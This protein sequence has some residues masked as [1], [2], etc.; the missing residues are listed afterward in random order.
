[1][2]CWKLKG[3]LAALAVLVGLVII[4]GTAFSQGRQDFTLVNK[5]GYDIYE[6]Y[7]SPTKASDWSDDVMDMDIL[8]HG[9][10]VEIVFPGDP[11]ICIWDLAV[12]YDDEEEVEWYNFDLCT[13]SQ[14]TL[15]YEKRSG[16][17]WAEYE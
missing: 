4:S 1:M 14:I 2:N 8:L 9:S 7:V 11:N 3:V 15:F 6:V 17:T 5:T 13:I 12:V 10:S 16:N